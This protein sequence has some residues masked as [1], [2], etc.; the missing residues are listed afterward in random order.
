MPKNL[1]EGV[2]TLTLIK[3]L[4]DEFVVEADLD[5]D[6]M[7]HLKISDF[8]AWCHLRMK[9]DTPATAAGATRCMEK[10]FPNKEAMDETFELGPD[11]YL[12][13]VQMLFDPF[14]LVGV[15]RTW[16]SLLILRRPPQRHEIE[17]VIITTQ[18]KYKEMEET[19]NVPMRVSPAEGQVFDDARV[20]MAVRSAMDSLEGLV[21]IKTCDGLYDSVAGGKEMAQVDTAEISQHGLG[22]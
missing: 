13:T 12:M 22:L 3:T 10:L 1:I 21:A 16:W 4:F 18:I 17:H 20:I 19:V 8:Y 7:L 2:P 14:I 15:M 5:T 11:I 9:G 6:Q